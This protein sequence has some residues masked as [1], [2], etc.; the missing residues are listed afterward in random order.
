MIRRPPRSTRTDTL[1]PYTTLFRS[2]AVLQ[3]ASVIPMFIILVTGIGLYINPAPNLFGWALLALS[4][5]AVNILIARRASSIE[6]TAAGTRKWR[7]RLLCGQV[8]IGVSWALFSV[9][10]CTACSGDGFYFYQGAVLLVAIAIAAMNGV[11]LRH[12]I[13]LGFLPLIVTLL[14]SAVLSRHLRSEESHVGEEG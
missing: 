3:G 14:V 4:V 12:G 1:F 8:L 5:H 10:D 7:L 13:L 11:L 9:Q 6:L 2:G